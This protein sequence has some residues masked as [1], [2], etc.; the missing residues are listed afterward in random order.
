MNT[1]KNKV[2]LIGRLGAK[3]EETI[4]ATGNKKT[5]FNLAV[6]ESFKDKA[7]EW[8]NKTEWHAITAWGKTAERVVKMLDKGIEV[9][10][11]GRLVN[12]SFETKDGQKRNTTEII[13][14]EFV[15]FSTKKQA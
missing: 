5:R 1:L 12:N 13:L 2:I 8:Q 4:F 6:N 11:E 10:I 14:N 3:P 9:M 7:G 15:L